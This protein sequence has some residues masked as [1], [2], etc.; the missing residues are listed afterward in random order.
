LTDARTIFYDRKK[1]SGK[2]KYVSNKRI[3]S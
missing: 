3:R 1:L 2:M